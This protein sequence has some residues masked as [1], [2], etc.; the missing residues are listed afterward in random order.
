MMYIIIVIVIALITI[1]IAAYFFIKN[2][3]NSIICQINNQT[4]KRE[5]NMG[6]PTVIQIDEKN[7]KITLRGMTFNYEMLD[8]KN[9]LIGNGAIKLQLLDN[10]RILMTE[11]GTTTSFW[12]KSSGGVPRGPINPYKI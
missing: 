11:G 6:P 1:G 2:Q 3:C 7:K 12:I 4:Y 9:L 5:D 8:D 10:D